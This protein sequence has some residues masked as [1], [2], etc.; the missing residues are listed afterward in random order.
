LLCLLPRA[1]SRL[2]CTII[3]STHYAYNITSPLCSLY[4]DLMHV[5]SSF[6][7][8]LISPS[9]ASLDHHSDDQIFPI[10][11]H[12]HM[13]IQPF[14]TE[15][16]RFLEHEGRLE[17]FLGFDDRDVL[18]GRFECRIDGFVKGFF[19]CPA[20]QNERK[21]DVPSSTSTWAL[22]C[23]RGGGTNR[24]PRNRSTSDGGRVLKVASSWGE[25]IRDA[26]LAGEWRER[27]EDIRRRWRRS[28][29][30]PRI[31]GRGRDGRL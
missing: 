25:S 16:S 28:I 24:S 20:V 4:N 30:K 21:Q 19:R 27:R 26:S 12:T 13:C 22:R 15:L 29:P 11:A 14:S 10:V 23:V 31:M 9:R 18:P 3:T 8:S 1:S 7:V 5:S 17:P 2:P 6:S